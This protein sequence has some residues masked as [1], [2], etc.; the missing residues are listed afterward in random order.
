MR[1]VPADV[2]IEPAHTGRTTAAKDIH[3][4][5]GVPAATRERV[6]GQAK[7][8]RFAARELLFSEGDVP[9]RLYV[10]LSGIVDLSRLHGQREC[11]VMMMLAG[12]LFMAAAT[13]YR[14]PSLISA[15]TL[16]PCKILVLDAETVRDEARRSPALARN[17]SQVLAG[18]WRVALRIILELKARLPS[19]RLAA[20][21]LRLHDSRPAGTIAEIPFSKRQLA[22]RIGMQPETLSRALQTLAANGLL[23]RGRQIIVNDRAK[24]E[25]FCGPDPY[26]P[27]NEGQLGVHTL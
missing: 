22:A 20:F 21:L 25:A 15:R 2:L 16:T 27:G 26:P 17:I 9:K 18:Q 7:V 10:V 13:L 11:N 23:L 3:L 6:L 14:E 19:E 4:L 8:E 24:A 12:D 5:A 1:H